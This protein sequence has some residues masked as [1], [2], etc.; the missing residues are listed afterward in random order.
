MTELKHIISGSDFQI[1]RI[2]TDA[3]DVDEFCSHK[4]VNP[5][6]LNKSLNLLTTGLA[7]FIS[8]FYPDNQIEPFFGDDERANNL[9]LKVYFE[10]DLDSSETE[11]LWLLCLYFF[12]E[13]AELVPLQFHMDSLG[14]A[15][16]EYHDN[17][18]IN[19]IFNSDLFKKERERAEK[20]ILQYISK[21]PLVNITRTVV[22]RM[23]VDR[24]YRVKVGG[25]WKKTKVKSTRQMR[26]HEPLIGHVAFVDYE[27]MMLHV[28]MRSTNKIQLIKYTLADAEYLP[29]QQILSARNVLHVIEVQESYA[30]DGIG[31]H[32][33][34]KSEFHFISVTEYKNDGSSSDEQNSLFPDYP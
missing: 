24:K 5:K 20:Y 23:N 31:E 22:F 28:R 2:R 18:D 15:I 12:S 25:A 8:I 13:V 27:K 30:I 4:H 21:I 16:V 14:E 29:S 7:Q 19:A 26:Q 33:E 6:S 10:L 32:D 17:L 9:S 3:G 1:E 34:K 11:N